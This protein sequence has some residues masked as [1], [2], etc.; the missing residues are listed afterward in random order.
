MPSYRSR[1]FFHFLYMVYRFYFVEMDFFYLMIASYLAPQRR[2]LASVYLVIFLSVAILFAGCSL[3]WGYLTWD[4]FSSAL[5][6]CITFNILISLR[7]IT[8][9]PLISFRFL[10]LVGESPLPTDL[11]SHEILSMNFLLLGGRCNIRSMHCPFLYS[12]FVQSQLTHYV[13][14]M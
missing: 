2:W 6:L 14:P 1:D 13:N 3:F 11:V 10:F 4:T 7:R 5:G 12:S 9:S 8:F